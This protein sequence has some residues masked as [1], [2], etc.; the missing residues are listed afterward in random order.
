MAAH[1]AQGNANSQRCDPGANRAHPDVNLDSPQLG[2]A[3]SYRSAPPRRVPRFP[4]AEDRTIAARIVLKWERGAIAGL[5]VTCNA[6]RRQRLAIGMGQVRSSRAT[7]GLAPVSRF[8]HQLRHCS[9]DAPSVGGRHSQGAVLVG[10]S[11]G[12]LHV[13]FCPGSGAQTAPRRLG[14]ERSSSTLARQDHHRVVP[15]GLNEPHFAPF[16]AET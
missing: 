14:P 5:A 9:A 6:M 1:R 3:A 16:R 15:S 10:G 4:A 2:A 7:G 11:G 13:T 12:A 8:A